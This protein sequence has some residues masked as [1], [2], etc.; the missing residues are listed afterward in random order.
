[1]SCKDKYLSFK[2][3]IFIKEKFKRRIRFLMR[4]LNNGMPCKRL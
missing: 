4:R 1:M 3:K 2:K